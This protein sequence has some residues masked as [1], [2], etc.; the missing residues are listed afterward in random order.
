MISLSYDPI[1]AKAKVFLKALFV[2]FDK[3]NKLLPIKDWY[4]T[5]I[6][7]PFFPPKMN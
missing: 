1:L 4:E 3:N 6:V 5:E 7:S 2:K